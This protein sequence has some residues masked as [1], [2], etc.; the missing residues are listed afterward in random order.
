MQKNSNAVVNNEIQ[1][2]YLVGNTTRQID[3][4][5]KNAI[6]EVA[7][8]ALIQ[9]IIDAKAAPLANHVKQYGTAKTSFVFAIAGDVTNNQI[10]MAKKNGLAGVVS[11]FNRGTTWNVKLTNRITGTAKATLPTRT[12]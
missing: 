7:P 8:C 3:A 9:P 10:K 1:K 6:K 4:A 5:L 11:T 12:Q 2:V